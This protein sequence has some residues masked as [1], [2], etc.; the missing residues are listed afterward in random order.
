[1]KWLKHA[2]AVEAPGPAEPTEPQRSAVDAVCTEIVKRWLSTPSLLF[3]EMSRP[4]NFIGSQSL[5]FFAPFISALTDAE[6]HKHFADFLE[7]RGSIDYIC[8]RIE[9]LEAAASHRDVNNDQNRP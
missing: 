1:V 3:L 4:L 7:N 8:R 9:Q 2:F 6:G 5:H